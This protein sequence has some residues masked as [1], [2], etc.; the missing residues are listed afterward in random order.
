MT[1]Q[2]INF[3]IASA[4]AQR[5][6]LCLFDRDGRQQSYE[7]PARSGDV[8]HGLLPGGHAGV[9]YAYRVY[10]PWQ[11]ASGLRFNPAKM[12]LDPYARALTT[13]YRSTSVCAVACMNRTGT[14]TAICCPAASSAMKAM[15]GRRTS[16]RTRP[17]I[18]R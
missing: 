4:H 2:G 6:E 8:W 1:P 14:I 12:V 10:G 16:R 11:P 18:V 13:R 5:I 3:A 7:L 15:P 9:E 17:G